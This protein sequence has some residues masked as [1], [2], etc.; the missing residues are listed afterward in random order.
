MAETLVT[1]LSFLKQLYAALA[2]KFRI[3]WNTKD[4]KKKNVIQLEILSVAG[5]PVAQFSEVRAAGKRKTKQTLAQR[6]LELLGDS[7]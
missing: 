6:A 1:E 5:E 4:F 2:A 7:T 3:K